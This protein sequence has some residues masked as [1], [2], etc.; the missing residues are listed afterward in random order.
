VLSQKRLVEGIHTKQGGFFHGYKRFPSNR[1]KDSKQFPENK[2]RFRADADTFILEL[3]RRRTVEE[4]VHVSS[5]EKGY[6][7]PCGYEKEN[8]L[9]PID[10]AKGK[11]NVGAILWMGKSTAAAT[12]DDM[13]EPGEF[14]TVG[15]PNG[16]REKMPVHNLKTLLGEKHLTD[17]RNKT[18][19]KFGTEVVVL[20]TKRV[21]IN[22]QLRL[23]KLQGYRA[24]YEGLGNTL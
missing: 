4:L 5:L 16:R 11:K 19:G 18:Q 24:T 22:V 23:W 9:S 13:P 6:I 2:I 17:L 8:D 15:L 1:L 21:T 14:A 12:M 3:M 7:V 20:R 10:C